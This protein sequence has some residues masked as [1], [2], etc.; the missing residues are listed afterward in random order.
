MNID[1]DDNPA[2]DSPTRTKI[3]IHAAQTI[4][5][6][7]AAL[8]QLI[9]ESLDAPAP[10]SL[11]PIYDCDPDRH[12]SESA[13]FLILLIN[14]LAGSDDD[15]DDLLH[16]TDHALDTTDPCND[17]PGIPCARCCDLCDA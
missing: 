7:L 3:L 10:T 2:I 4:G 11:F 6:D 14:T 8:P 12:P 5:Y 1:I 13:A 16:D 17:H 15:H 9:M